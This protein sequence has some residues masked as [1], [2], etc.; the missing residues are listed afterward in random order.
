VSAYIGDGLNRWPAVH[1]LD[2]AIM[3]SAKLCAVM[4]GGSDGSR[5]D[6][7]IVGFFAAVFWT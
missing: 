3:H 7:G 6:I 4:F 5:T 2:A 1:R